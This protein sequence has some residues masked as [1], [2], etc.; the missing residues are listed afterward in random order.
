ME[1]EHQRRDQM[2]DGIITCVK[3]VNSN[4]MEYFFIELDD[5]HSLMKPSIII[6]I[7]RHVEKFYNNL[8]SS[9]I[10]SLTVIVI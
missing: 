2:K 6:E 3:L 7:K 4:L 5:S 1:E 8:N 9:S 10:L